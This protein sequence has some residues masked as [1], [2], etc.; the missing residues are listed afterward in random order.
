MYPLVKH[1]NNGRG[2][3]CVGAGNRWE[4]SVPFAHFCCEPKTALK[5]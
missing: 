2:C 4:I 1:V 3:A 5:E